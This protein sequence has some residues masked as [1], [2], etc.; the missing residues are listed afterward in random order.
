MVNVAADWL[1]WSLVLVSLGFWL[2]RMV[3]MVAIGKLVHIST[4]K[5]DMDT[6]DENAGLFSSAPR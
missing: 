2:G 5:L 3:T 1:R 6:P 4:N